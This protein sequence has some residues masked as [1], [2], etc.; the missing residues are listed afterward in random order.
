MVGGKNCHAY[1][2]AVTL[3]LAFSLFTPALAQEVEHARKDTSAGAP[4]TSVTQEQLNNA[5]D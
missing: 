2:A 1:A 3:A 5:A 4:A